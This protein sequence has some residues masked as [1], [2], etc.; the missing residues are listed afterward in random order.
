MFLLGKR[1]CDADGVNPCSRCLRIN[2]PCE[3]RAAVKRKAKTGLKKQKTELVPSASSGL[4]LPGMLADLV[5]QDMTL[6]LTRPLDFAACF[7]LPLG[8]ENW[9]LMQY[10]R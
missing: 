9:M 4:A 5:M 2:K 7:G 10:S 1:A 3:P 6:V 8:G